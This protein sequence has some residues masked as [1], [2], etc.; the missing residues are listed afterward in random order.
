MSPS[1]V[2]FNEIRAFFRYFTNNN[3]DMKSC[4]ST[5]LI[6]IR[7]LLMLCREWMY[8]FVD[9]QLIL[10][11]FIISFYGVVGNRLF[12]VKKSIRRGITLNK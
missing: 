3:I 6:V 11:L 5:D 7:S 8:F 4:L 12:S 9:I 10:F 2:V 1:S